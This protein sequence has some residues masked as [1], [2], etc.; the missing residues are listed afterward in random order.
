MVQVL[1]QQGNIFGR[2]G[3]GI[4]Q[5]LSE[6]LPAE[7]QKGRLAYGLENLQKEGQNLNPLQASAQ[8]LRSG[9]TPE[10]VSQFLPHIQ[11]ATKG[12][13]FQNRGQKSQ[14]VS[15]NSIKEIIGNENKKPPSLG[16]LSPEEIQSYKSK[17]LQEPSFE[18]IEEGARERRARGEAFTREDALQQEKE[19]KHQN[20][21]SQRDKIASTRK[22]VN[23][24]FAL[25]LQN[26]GLGDYKD[27][28]GPIQQALLDR[29]DYNI[30]TKGM[31]AQESSKNISDILEELGKT[32]TQTKTTGSLFLAKPQEMKN[33]LI[34]QKKTFD[35]Y[36]F[37]EVFDDIATKSLGITPIKAAS[38]LD[39]IKNKETLNVLKSIKKNPFSPLFTSIDEKKLNKL[40]NSIEPGDNILSIAN[41]LRDKRMDVGQFIEKVRKRSADLTPEQQRQLDKPTRNSLFGDIWFSARG[42]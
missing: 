26:S 6:T 4:G 40:V 22:D 31:T 20:L 30:L 28:A 2:L 14:V 23:D 15:S 10:Q 3:K 29:A 16:K 37:G 18:E 8:L 36:G 39:P 24:R 19:S 25:T 13:A 32:A 21:A 11:Q 42:G 27:V 7:I 35:K 12:E 38:F 5:G 9:A 1:E 33:S 34:Q 17:I 41:E